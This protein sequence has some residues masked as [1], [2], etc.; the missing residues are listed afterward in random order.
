MACF[1]EISKHIVEEIR[2]KFALKGRLN[3]SQGQRPWVKTFAPINPE[4]VAQM[5]LKKPFRLHEI[6]AF[7]PGAL[8]LAKIECT[9]SG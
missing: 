8:P 9:L 6:Y 5:D 4:G 7:D 1:F 2:C 3:F